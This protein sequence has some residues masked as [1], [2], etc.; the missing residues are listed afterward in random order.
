MTFRMYDEQKKKKKTRRCHWLTPNRNQF[1]KLVRTETNQ[2]YHRY[3]GVQAGFFSTK[4][5]NK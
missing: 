4:L 2:H 3:I 1:I 5:I